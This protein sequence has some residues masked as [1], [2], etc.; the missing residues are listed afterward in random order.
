MSVICCGC[1]NKLLE[2]NADVLWLFITSQHADLRLRNNTMPT[3][4]ER[5]S[6][7]Q[8]RTRKTPT[9]IPNQSSLKSITGASKKYR[10]FGKS[11]SGHSEDSSKAD[12]S[13]DSIMWTTIGQQRKVRA[14]MTMQRVIDKTNPSWTYKQYISL[15]SVYEDRDKSKKKSMCGGSQKPAQTHPL[16]QVKFHKILFFAK[17][18]MSGQYGNMQPATD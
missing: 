4:T 17:T 7:S 2:R 10:N 6:F 3:V 15:D 12:E 9:C 5:R 8:T 16:L 14:D 13:I 1:K 11:V 18:N